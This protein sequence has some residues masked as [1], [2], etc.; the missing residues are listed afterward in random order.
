MPREMRSV[1]RERRFRGE[2]EAGCE[3]D[4]SSKYDRVQD[5]VVS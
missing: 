3:L 1:T 2:N 4:V 5:L